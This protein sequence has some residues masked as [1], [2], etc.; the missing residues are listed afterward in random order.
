MLAPTTRNGHTPV[1][2]FSMEI[3]L[4][5]AMP[6]YSGGLGVLAG[7]TL[8]SAAD[9]RVPLVGVT[10]LHRKGYFYQRLDASGRQFEEP[11]AWMPDDVLTELPSRTT[12]TIEGRLVHIRA[13][14]YDVTGLGGASVPVYLLDTDL[15]GNTEWDRH[16]TDHLYGGDAHYR[17]CQEVVLGIGG[18]RMLRALGHT[19]ISLFHMNE[20]HS[21]LLVLALL[22]ERLRRE[23]RTDNER[24][25]G[26]R[27][28]AMRI[29]DAHAC[30]GWT[31]PV[32]ARIGRPGAGA[33]GGPRDEGR[34]LL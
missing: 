7:D 13:W 18:V 17:L 20:G 33:A 4:D 24:G 14:R 9:L 16:L 5:V 3:A 26:G 22:D 32:L 28:P 12:V 2:Y 8:R 11:V 10:L 6:T 23:G 19:D 29:H 30:P 21:S 1:A 27:S 15:P 25:R 34:V 31:R